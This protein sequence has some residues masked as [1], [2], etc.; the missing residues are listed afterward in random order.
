[1][2]GPVLVVVVDLPAEPTAVAYG[3]QA[4]AP[5]TAKVST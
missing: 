3:R 4:N 2:S 5:T 1:M